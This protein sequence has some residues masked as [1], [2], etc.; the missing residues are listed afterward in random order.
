MATEA[1]PAL[2]DRDA[3]QDK[4]SLGGGG[5]QVTRM[6]SCSL[7]VWN[8]AAEWVLCQPPKYGREDLVALPLLARQKTQSSF[9]VE[10]LE[11]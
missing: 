5:G 3:L 6:N 8:D 2:K 9:W 7:Q 11:G 4:E 10:V 1:H